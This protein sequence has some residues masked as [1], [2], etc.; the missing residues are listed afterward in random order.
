MELNLSA[1]S[2]D[3]DS[4]LQDPAGVNRHN[5]TNDPTN[6]VFNDNNEEGGE[7]KAGSSSFLAETRGIDGLREQMD[8]DEFVRKSF[9]F[10]FDSIKII[11]RRADLPS[12]LSSSGGRYYRRRV[13]RREVS[14]NDARTICLIL[15]ERADFLASVDL[16]TIIERDHTFIAEHRIACEKLCHSF[17]VSRLKLFELNREKYA[18]DLTSRDWSFI[19]DMLSSR[20][21]ALQIYR[22]IAIASERLRTSQRLNVDLSFSLIHAHVRV[23]VLHDLVTRYLIRRYFCFRGPKLKVSPFEPIHAIDVD[24]VNFFIFLVN[25]FVKPERKFEACDLAS[26]QDFWFSVLSHCASISPTTFIS[27]IFTYIVPLETRLTL[28]AHDVLDYV[29]WLCR[30]DPWYLHYSSGIVERYRSF[31]ENTLKRQ[32]ATLYDTDNF[33]YFVLVANNITSRFDRAKLLVEQSISYNDDET[34]LSHSRRTQCH[35]SHD[36]NFVEFFDYCNQTGA[37]VVNQFSYNWFELSSKVFSYDCYYNT[38]EFVLRVIEIY[39]LYLLE[40]TTTVVSTD[41][42]HDQLRTLLSP[43][44]AVS[45]NLCQILGGIAKKRSVGNNEEIVN[46]VV[47][48][49]GRSSSL[50]VTRQISSGESSTSSQGNKQRGSRNNRGQCEGGGGGGG[51][52]GSRK[53]KGSRNTEKSEEDIAKCKRNK[54]ILQNAVN[55]LN[56]ICLLYNGTF[57]NQSRADYLQKFDKRV[58]KNLETNLSKRWRDDFELS[59]FLVTPSDVDWNAVEENCFRDKTTESPSISIGNFL[60][61]HKTTEINMYFLRILN[62]SHSFSIYNILTRRYEVCAPSLMYLLRLDYKN[63]F[64][65]SH[66]SYPSSVDRGIAEYASLCLENIDSFKKRIVAIDS[67]SMILHSKLI[68]EKKVGLERFDAPSS[69][70]SSL[71]TQLISANVTSSSTS[72]SVNPVVASSIDETSSRNRITRNMFRVNADDDSASSS[73][74]QLE[75]E[76]DHERSSAS[77]SYVDFVIDQAEF[78]ELSSRIS[79]AWVHDYFVRSI[80]RR[81]YGLVYFFLAI[82]QL[83]SQFGI[84]FVLQDSFQRVVV[85]EIVDSYVRRCALHYAESQR[86]KYAKF[87]KRIHEKSMSLTVTSDN[88][89]SSAGT[90]N[91][92]EGT[93]EKNVIPSRNVLVNSSA[94]SLLDDFNDILSTPFNEEDVNRENFNSTQNPLGSN[95]SINADD[96]VSAELNDVT[97]NSDFSVIL[98][99]QLQ[100]C[101]A[102]NSVAQLSHSFDRRPVTKLIASSDVNSTIERDHSVSAVANVNV[103]NSNQKSSSDKWIRSFDESISSSGVNDTS[104]VGDSSSVSFSAK[105]RVTRNR[106]RAQVVGGGGGGGGNGS[107]SGRSG[108]RGDGRGDGYSG[109]NKL[110]D[111]IVTD[112]N[113]RQVFAKLMHDRDFFSWLN[114]DSRNAAKTF[115]LSNFVNM[116]DR[117]FIRTFTLY[118]SVLRALDNF[119][120]GSKDS[121]LVSNVSN[122]KV[123]SWVV[124]KTRPRRDFSLSSNI[125]A[126][127]DVASLYYNLDES[128]LPRDLLYEDYFEEFD[129]DAVDNDELPVEELAKIRL[130]RI[131]RVFDMDI[132]LRHVFSQSKDPTTLCNYFWLNAT[133]SLKDLRSFFPSCFVV[134]RGTINLAESYVDFLDSRCLDVSRHVTNARTSRRRS[135]RRHRRRAARKDDASYDE[136]DRDHEY[137]DEDEDDDDDDS[138]RFNTSIDFDLNLVNERLREARSAQNVMSDRFAVIDDDESYNDLFALFSQKVESMAEESKR[139]NLKDRK[140]RRRRSSGSNDVADSDNSSPLNT[141][142]RTS[143]ITM[144][145]NERNLHCSHKL[146]ESFVA[147]PFPYRLVSRE[148]RLSIAYTIFVIYIFC[149]CDIAVTL[150][151]LKFLVSP[152][153]PGPWSKE[154][155]ASVFIGTSNSGK[156]RLVNLVRRF[157][158]SEHGNLNTSILDASKD[159]ISTAFFPIASNLVCQIDEPRECD[160]ETL[161]NLISDTPKQ[162]RAF[163]SQQQQALSN[164]AKIFITINQ[165]FQIVSDDGVLTRLQSFFRVTHRHLDT[166][167]PQSDVMKIN[168]EASMN[169]AHQFVSQNYPKGLHEQTFLRGLFF[170]IFHWCS[171]AVTF[172]EERFIFAD[173]V[174]S[175]NRE[176]LRYLAS[177]DA[178]SDRCS[179]LESLPSRVVCSFDRK[180]DSYFN[181]CSSNSATD[182][183]SFRSDEEQTTTN[184]NYLT[185]ALFRKLSIARDLP[186][187]L[188]IN[189]SLI[190]LRKL[191]LIVNAK[192]DE[193]KVM[194]FFTTYPR[195]HRL[196][197]YLSDVLFANSPTLLSSARNESSAS[198]TAVSN[199]HD[200]SNFYAASRL[201]KFIDD[202]YDDNHV[203]LAVKPYKLELLTSEM[204][205]NFDAF[206]RFQN[207]HR[208]IPAETPMTREK[209]EYHLATFLERFN[210]TIT[211]AK[212]R[213]KFSE[214]Y[215][216]FVNEYSKFQYVDPKTNKVIPN[217]W[218]LRVRSTVHV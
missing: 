65:N 60:A 85:N 73:L 136:E 151:M 33:L 22:N 144:E 195:K 86:S 78:L 25:T 82:V 139:D 114:S 149:G 147:L 44:N 200:S 37:H 125:N 15:K 174:C 48:D 106:R 176:C 152:L 107:A 130:Q 59:N 4:F 26:S 198:S 88:S 62:G 212:Y 137:E 105:R 163:H 124:R 112:Q 116:S 178:A 49:E 53:K 142:S 203:N 213:V 211:D 173:I 191:F 69:F 27:Q 28:S 186:S 96:D 84:S 12:V 34:R 205:N 109:G 110:V 204:H 122:I 47:T 185:T 179:N 135:R 217:K 118:L 197:V 46:V 188:G 17:Y 56:D 13:L 133:N 128:D 99:K 127:N 97:N 215:E 52:K 119:N 14:R 9:D 172:R 43:N 170:L 100:L 181:V 74:S 117:S 35:E 207:T 5:D 38:F 131:S 81:E 72:S 101:L 7:R 83:V 168:G 120:L 210:A 98:R 123:T 19:E 206:V 87:R 36:D 182:D 194:N 55:F 126:T 157:Y 201:Y 156:S 45:D 20:R 90:S 42:C 161:K 184:N 153:F 61:Q 57:M 164:I 92:V 66:E 143:R 29:S 180:L 187:F 145:K 183:V 58:I 1:R 51:D 68:R 54:E 202:D 150:Y 2:V 113:L 154:S 146:F 24:R 39:V 70:F 91:A 71:S 31:N 158:N 129:F 132:L 171:S 77:A 148:V 63:W 21:D 76:L 40:S 166:V 104:C 169:V 18:G 138:S 121:D 93:S 209:L 155:T 111:E 192:V 134:S 199:S 165:M 160:A 103:C 32:F 75:S 214:F 140:R 159:N 208:V 141:A 108:G 80:E 10:F 30:E 177:F 41:N 162:A 190:H 3:E 79:V 8:R 11:L 189:R 67:M 16:L 196:L 167:K 89:P 6:K 175:H 218:S 102:S 50:A 216:R 115:R 94:Y 64:L 193:V 95:R 23:V